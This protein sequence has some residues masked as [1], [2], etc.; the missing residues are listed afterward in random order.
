VIGV[1][2]IGQIRRAFFEQRRAIKEISR[3]LRVSRTTVRKVVRS[4]RTAFRYVREVQPSP[5]LGE[6]RGPLLEI[7]EAEARLA[8]RERRSTQRLF[9]ELRGRGYD[10]AHDSVHRFVKE[11]REERARVSGAGVCADELCAGRSLSVRLEPR[12]DHA[13]RLAADGQGGAHEAVAQPDAVCADLLPGDA[14]T[15]VRC[16]RQGL[17]ILW[18]GVSARH[19]R[20]HED[21]GRGDLHR[22]GAA[23]QS[24]VPADV[25]AS[26]D[27]AGG[28]QPGLRLGEGSGREPGRQPCAISCSDPS[29]GSAVWSS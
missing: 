28:L 6:W 17:R 1:D 8:K 27:R 16:P 18:R 19:L 10:G 26:S 22:Q 15:G 9:E 14:G 25:L 11:W 7:V 23:V 21:G 20:Q 4:D 29:R 2:L 13:A 12:D 5:K 3:D 24:A